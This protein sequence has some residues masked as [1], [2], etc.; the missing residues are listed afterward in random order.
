MKREG[1]RMLNFRSFFSFLFFIFKWGV[2][3][4]YF[5]ENGIKNAKFEG[6]K[7]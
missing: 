4:F 7:R 2:F 3:Y 6:I 5:D 1:E